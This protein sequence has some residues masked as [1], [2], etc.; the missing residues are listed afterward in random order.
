MDTDRAEEKSMKKVPAISVMLIGVGLCSFAANPTW[1]GD[2][3]HWRGAEQNGVSRDTD[4][5]ESWSLDPADPNSN[6][7]WKAPYGCRS[8]PL[9]MGGKVFIIN[10]DGSGMN[11]G[12][13]IV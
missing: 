2:W 11:E 8:T 13:R 10:S 12:E 1:A 5:P 7:I 3:L 9:I 6:L 4:L